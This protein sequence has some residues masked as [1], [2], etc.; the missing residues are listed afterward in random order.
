MVLSNNEPIE[1]EDSQDRNWGAVAHIS[2]LIPLPLFDL[3]GPFIILLTKGDDSFF[4]RRQ[5]I[6]ALNFRI[7]VLLAYLIC[8]PLIFVLIGIPM[9]WIVGI[10]SLIL[11]V[12]AA[13]KATEGRTYRYPFSLRLLK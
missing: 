8:L 12:I 4:V 1:S 2:A 9:L 10:G 11:T 13:I 6:S 7:T 3:P 5:A